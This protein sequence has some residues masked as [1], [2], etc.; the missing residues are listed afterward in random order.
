MRMNLF[1]IS[2]LCSLFIVMQLNHEPVLEA[3]LNYANDPCDAVFILAYYRNLAT[4]HNSGRPPDVGIQ[5]P[6]IDSLYQSYP[7]S[8]LQFW[9]KKFFQN[10]N[11]K[12]LNDGWLLLDCF[13]IDI[14]F[15][16]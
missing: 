14:L 8:F 10:K 4:T 12:H 11:C 15:L 2:P 5:T 13:G 6:G 3:S 7:L 16:L 9:R 1:I